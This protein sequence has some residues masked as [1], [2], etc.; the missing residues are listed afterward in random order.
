[1]PLRDWISVH[2]KPADYAR[3][4]CTATREFVLQYHSLR[5][6]LQPLFADCKI[7]VYRLWK[8][9]SDACRAGAA[10][11][12]RTVIAANNLVAAVRVVVRAKRLEPTAGGLSIN[13]K[14][15]AL[16]YSTRSFVTRHGKNFPNLNFVYTKIAAAPNRKS[17][18]IVGNT[19]GCSGRD[20]NGFAKKTNTIAPQVPNQ[21]TF[22]NMFF[23]CS[24]PTANASLL[25]QRRSRQS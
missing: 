22:T 1:V 4:P 10:S 15:S 6:L 16:N 11:I 24:T 5:H 21:T 3:L 8:R 7:P 20:R 19:Y 14:P 17:K 18:H 9:L 25:V 2:L 13:H 23:I 12:M